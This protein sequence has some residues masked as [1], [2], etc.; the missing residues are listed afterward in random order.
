MEATGGKGFWGWSKPYCSFCGWNVELAKERERA[1]LK[2]MVLGL[3]FFGVIF[4]AF[5]YIS[6][7]GFALFPFLILS[8]F[9]VGNAISAWR[10]LR[11]LDASRTAAASTTPLSTV[12]AGKERAKH[13]RDAAYQQLTALSKPRQVR[14][15]VVPRVVLIASP[16][17][18]VLT[19]WLG[20]QVFQNGFDRSSLLNDLMPLLIMTGVWSTI[21]VVVLRSAWKHRRLLAE[22]NLAIATVTHQWVSGGKHQRSQIQYEF[23]DAAGR[24]VKS[25]T[26]EESRTLYEEMETPIFYNPDNSAENVVLACASCELKKD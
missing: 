22:G 24:L 3:V 19:V 7:E 23:K 1:K 14:F 11:T 25:E 26:T 21:T 6:K 5:A 17:L 4:G 15:K 12:T 2:Q 13:D 9:L 16:F 18:G 10:N 20:F 8:V